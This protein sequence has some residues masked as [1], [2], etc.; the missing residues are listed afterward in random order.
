MSRKVST[1]LLAIIALG[2]CDGASLQE[3]QIE[4]K[5]GVYTGPDELAITVD[6]VHGYASV[7]GVWSIEGDDKIA[8]PINISKIWCDKAD[9]YCEDHRAYLSTGSGRPML[10][11]SDDLYTVTSWSDD[12]VTAELMHPGCR[13]I[14]LE[15]S[16]PE[17][18][19]TTITRQQGK[20]DELTPDLKKPRLGLLITGQQ[21]DK[22]RGL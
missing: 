15:I 18:A 7:T 10:M 13:T 22:Q 20:C 16:K 12:K 3:K 21:L 6:S 17:K 5:F 19:V 9:S 8:D 1:C 2:S 14:R 11:A 4:R